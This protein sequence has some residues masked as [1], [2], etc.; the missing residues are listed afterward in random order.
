M[1]SMTLPSRMKKDL[2]VE[3]LR[4]VCGACGAAGRTLPPVDS[5]ARPEADK[6]GQLTAAFPRASVP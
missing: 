4:L 3:V 5:M 2:K 1:A 6:T